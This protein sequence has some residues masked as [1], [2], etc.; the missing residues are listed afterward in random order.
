M[1]R[2][3]IINAKNTIECWH[4]IPK[5]RKLRYEDGRKVTR[6]RWLKYKSRSRYRD[7]FMCS[8][9]MHASKDLFDAMKYSRGFGQVLCRVVLKG[10]RIYGKSKICAEYRSVTWMID[11]DPLFFEIAAKICPRKWIKIRDNSGRLRPRRD[12]E[13]TDWKAWSKDRPTVAL[14]RAIRQSSYDKKKC[15][16]IIM[17]EILKEKM[18][19]DKKKRRR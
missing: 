13:N 15:K 14:R 5:N 12:K 18:K 17:T 10:K 19:Q 3:C 2:N 8:N 7:L 4:F 1:N 16:Q 6:N 9:G 11:I